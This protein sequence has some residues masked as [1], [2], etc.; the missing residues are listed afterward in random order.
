MKLKNN[1]INNRIAGHM[2]NFFFNK[3][4]KTSVQLFK[5]FF[6]GGI[7]YTV[8]F[9]SL[10]ILTDLVKV[11]YLISAAIAF[12]LGLIT[13]YSLSIVWVFSKRTLSN[14]RLEFIVFSIIGLVGLGMNE[15]IIWFFTEWIHFHYLIS[16]IFST[17]VVFFW[18]FFA[19]KKIL[20]S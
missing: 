19:R 2:R 8:D 17:V 7:A 14:R 9:G 3:S 4:D 10:F 5:Y 12:T 15:V 6:V 13:N 18:N 16:K 1:S 11:H 20:F